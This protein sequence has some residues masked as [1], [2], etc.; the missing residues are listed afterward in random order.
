MQKYQTRDENEDREVDHILRMFTSYK[1]VTTSM[2][3]RTR[4]ETAGFTYQQKNG[5]FYRVVHEGR[6]DSDSAGLSRDLGERL[7]DR[8]SIGQA[9]ES[10]VGMVEP[11]ILPG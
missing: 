6:K 7:S 1:T 10:E 11:R 8:K 5:T 3:A 4:W 2:T 9:E